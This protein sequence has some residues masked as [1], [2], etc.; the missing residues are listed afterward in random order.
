M[1]MKL[2]KRVFFGGYARETVLAIANKA[3]GGI[4]IAMVV[5]YADNIL[6]GYASSISIILSSTVSY[7]VFNFNITPPIF[8]LSVV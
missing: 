2:R 8:L 4:V 6:K 3:F 5:K 7:F 1:G